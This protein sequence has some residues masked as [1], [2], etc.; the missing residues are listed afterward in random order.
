[1]NLRGVPR[2]AP[3]VAYACAAVLMVGYVVVRVQ[4]YIVFE[5]L[6]VGEQFRGA[7]PLEALLLGLSGIA[8]AVGF[9]AHGAL[10]VQSHRVA[11]WTPVGG[12]LCGVAAFT[13]WY[14]LAVVQ[15][16]QM[17]D[18]LSEPHTMH[19]DPTPLEGLLGIGLVTTLAAT[20]A[21]RMSV[22]RA[23]RD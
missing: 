17:I 8:L 7:A 10:A 11:R 15:W 2:A 22:I 12:A 20:I 3:G 21:L 4:A 19:R 13:T 18:S 1:M 5:R 16:W 6:M 9:A 23:S 14:A